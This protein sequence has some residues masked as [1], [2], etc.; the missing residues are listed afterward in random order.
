MGVLTPVR[1]LQ[2]TGLQFRRYRRLIN[3]LYKRSLRNRMKALRL[4]FWTQ[5][6]NWLGQSQRLDGRAVI[7]GSGSGSGVGRMNFHSATFAVTNSIVASYDA[8]G[9]HGNHRNGNI[10]WR[11]SASG[12]RRLDSSGRMA[13]MKLQH[14]IL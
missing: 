11:R 2:T 8:A 9:T 3:G 12:T 6:T 4:S 13:S 7:W 14:V 10:G 5:D 1:N